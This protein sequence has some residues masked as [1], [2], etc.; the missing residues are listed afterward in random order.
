MVYTRFRTRTYFHYIGNRAF[1]RDSTVYFSDERLTEKITLSRSFYRHLKHP[2]PAASFF[3]DA[4]LQ[5]IHMRCRFLRSFPSDRARQ[6]IVAMASAIDELLAL[7]KPNVVLGPPMDSYVLDLLDRMAARRRIP[8]MGLV[9]TFADG[10]ARITSRGE[11]RPFRTP[12]AEE[13]EAVYTGISAKRYAPYYVPSV[14][15]TTQ[16]VFRRFLKDHGRKAL[17]AL[18]RLLTNDP[19]CFYL[20]QFH[21]KEQITGLD[22]RQSF[23]RLNTDPDWAQAAIAGGKPV[24]YFP[25]QFYPETSIDYLSLIHI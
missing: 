3:S 24:I 15:S 20:N 17:F 22:L 23:S 12:S 13:V 9:V 4:E 16:L 21:F 25:L 18:L 19:L 11:L 7:Y 10:Y 14:R 6:M 5:D 8:Y 2:N 1:G